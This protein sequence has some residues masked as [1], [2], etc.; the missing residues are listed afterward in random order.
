MIKVELFTHDPMLTLV[1]SESQC[2][3]LFDDDYLDEYGIEIHEELANEAISTYYKL[4]EISEKL[5]KIRKASY[6]K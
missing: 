4:L 5:D 3:Q 2:K 6:G 1:R